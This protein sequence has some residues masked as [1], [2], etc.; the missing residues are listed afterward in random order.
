MPLFVKLA[1]VTQGRT[2]PETSKHRRA[3][4]NKV[5]DFRVMLACFVKGFQQ[6]SVVIIH[7][8]VVGE[9]AEAAVI[10]MFAEYSP[11]SCKLLKSLLG[12]VFGCSRFHLNDG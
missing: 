2:F 4:A 6:P 1:V 7:L 12:N 5:D 11:D 3:D 8:V 10:P 9:Q